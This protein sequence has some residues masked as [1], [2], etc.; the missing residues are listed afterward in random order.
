MKHAIKP[1]AP[2]RIS[3]V[4]AKTKIK[5]PV[6]A[7]TVW[8]SA[9]LPHPSILDLLRKQQRS[10]SFQDAQASPSNAASSS[11]GAIPLP[12]LPKKPIL[13]DGKDP[14]ELIGEP[15]CSIAKLQNDIANGRFDL[16]GNPWVFPGDPFQ[17]AMA[18]NTRRQ[19]HGERLID[20]D[21]ALHLV[22][23]PTLFVWSPESLCPGFEMH[24]PHCH[25]PAVVKRW[26]SPRIM[27]SLTGQCMYMS[28]QY[29]CTDCPTVQQ[30]G[31]T[32][33]PGGNPSGTKTARRRKTF[34]TDN[35]VLMASLPS[36]IASMWDLTDTGGKICDSSMSDLV[37]SL[38]TRTSWSAIAETI[39]EL[40]ATAWTKSVVLRYLQLCV[41]LRIL[42]SSIPR[43]LPTEYQI[44]ATWVRNLY[45]ADFDQRQVEV[46]E[47]LAGETG[48]DI[49]ILDW[50][51]DAA[52]QCGSNF[53]FNVVAGNR[54]LL[55]TK[56]TE[57]AAPEEV[58]PLI[59]ELK[60]R[61]VHP[62]VVYVDDGCCG[63]WKTFLNKV[64]P[65]VRVRLDGMHAMRRLT[66]TTS[67]TKHPW[68]GRFCAA[69]SEAIYTYDPKEK[70]RFEL[71]WRRAGNMGPVPSKLLKK[72]VPRVIC[73][74]LR[75]TA[76]IDAV[77]KS[78]IEKKCGA[79][80]GPL[81]TDA[82]HAAWANLKKH[83]AQGCLCD[84][85]GI[86]LHAYQQHASLTIGEEMFQTFHT[87]RGTSC[88]EGLH[89]HQK[90]PLGPLAHH[91]PESG[92]ALL[93]DWQQR[94]NRK[95]DSNA[96]ENTENPLPVFA[97]GVI[98]TANALHQQLTGATLYK[99]CKRFH[100]A[101][102]PHQ[103][104]PTV[105]MQ[106]QRVRWRFGVLRPPE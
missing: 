68:H 35:P 101:G 23:R 102:Q 38:A 31:N 11:E 54:K 80:V 4:G 59:W 42:P 76:S 18:I 91:G 99:S 14:K 106:P 46:T 64:W 62:K 36:R 29:T 94:W 1:V 3:K 105:S 27:H 85:F 51:V 53:L 56:L 26:N 16:K 61:G 83:V 6:P 55:T 17:D 52:K 7:N 57:S 50:T 40:K 20:S 70:S 10:A 12:L 74:S 34:M 75:I 87:L 41:M 8:Q 37:R 90:L 30:S 88:L 21:E 63:C 45:V 32:L 98:Q 69:L 66:A 93:S 92:M 79:Q 48:D 104:S 67:S 28:M 58:E 43:N 82:T 24:C 77:V 49:L 47:E 71:A 39:N 81:L 97:G 73:N 95:R 60:H 22:L 89:T 5:K 84:P 15:E 19:K 9:P 103:E 96:A 25:H 78:H 13:R 72:Y 100:S 33:Q 65:G 44:H 86:P 2:K